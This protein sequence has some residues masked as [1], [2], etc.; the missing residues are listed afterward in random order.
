MGTADGA[1]WSSR[2]SG[3]VDRRI[4]KLL[5]I[6]GSSVAGCGESEIVHAIRP[7]PMERRH[8]RT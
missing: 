4:L 8:K 2:R 7:L 5:A 6:L 1:R 3:G